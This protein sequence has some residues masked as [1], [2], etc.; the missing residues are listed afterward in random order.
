VNQTGWPQPAFGIAG[1]GAPAPG[2]LVFG[3]NGRLI[4]LVTGAPDA[5]RLLT[6]DALQNLVGQLK[7]NPGVTRP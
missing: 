5:A 4:G 1:Q 6:A 3:I 7:A 2:A